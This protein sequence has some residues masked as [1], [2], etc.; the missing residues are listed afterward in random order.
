MEAGGRD[1]FFLRNFKCANSYNDKRTSYSNQQYTYTKRAS[2]NNPF[3]IF[4]LIASIK[5]IFTKKDV[6]NI[7]FVLFPE[8]PWRLQPWEAWQD[9]NTSPQI[10]SSRLNFTRK[11]NKKLFHTRIMKMK[12]KAIRETYKSFFMVEM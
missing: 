3:F 9:S 6:S 8:S 5:N 4:L 12:A 1:M 10:I 11:T 2:I 7:F